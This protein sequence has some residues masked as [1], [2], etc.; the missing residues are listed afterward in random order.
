MP[1]TKLGGVSMS[2]PMNRLDEASHA[3]K[4]KKAC[5][6]KKALPARYEAKSTEKA[7]AGNLEKLCSDWRLEQANAGDVGSP[8][9]SLMPP[10]GYG[11]MEP[12][13]LQ[14]VIFRVR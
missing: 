14:K 3:D 2:D 4:S 6:A 1:A 13:M 5:E 8:F 9:H 10:Y 12:A 11:W 7:Q